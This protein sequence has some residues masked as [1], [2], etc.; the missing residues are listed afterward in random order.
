MN[1]LMFLEY[2]SVK[3]CCRWRCWGSSAQ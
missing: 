3:S 2:Y 1:V